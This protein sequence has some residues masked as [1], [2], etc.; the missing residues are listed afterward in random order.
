MTDNR[1]DIVLGVVYNAGKDKVLAAR[2]PRHSHLGGLWEFPGGKV[3][4]CENPL[5][6]LKRELFE[7][8]NIEVRDCSPLISFDY[9]YPDKSLRFHVWKIHGWAGELTGKEG[10]ETQWVD[11]SSLAVQDFPAA[12][13]GIIAACKLPALYLITPDL[14]SYTPAF[15]SE[16]QAYLAAGVKLVQFRSKKSDIREPAL[17]EMISACRSRGAEL[18]VNSTPEFAMDVGAAGVHLTS[19]RLLE[20]TGRPLPAGP[21]VGASCHDPRELNHAVQTGIDFCVLSQV[22][23]SS[24]KNGISLGWDRFSDMIRKI[25]VPV[26]ALGGMKLSDLTIARQHG[27]QGIALISDVWN[28]PDSAARLMQASYEIQ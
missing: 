23:K 18:I 15:V 17:S 1:T 25:P 13:K 14:D 9:D 27:A 21:W 11:I 28:R 5:Q 3:K 16:L 12:N 7:E 22:S 2:R 26:Y 20:L 8:I 24:G 4:S 6:A 10:Q 19:K